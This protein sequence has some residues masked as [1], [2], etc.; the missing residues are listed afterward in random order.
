MQYYFYK[1][2]DNLEIVYVPVHLNVIFNEP[3]AI[4]GS[5]FL[6]DEI[7]SEMVKGIT[8]ETNKCYIIDFQNIKE[9]SS[10]ATKKFIDVLSPEKADLIF[11]NI[12]EAIKGQLFKE[13]SGYLNFTNFDTLKIAYSKNGWGYFNEFIGQGRDLNTAI[14]DIKEKIIA[15]HLKE[16][17]KEENNYLE[18]SNVYSKYYV[19]VKTVF[20]TS[21]VFYLV[22][23]EMCKNIVNN[24]IISNEKNKFTSTLDLVCVSNNGA[25]LSKIIGQVLNLNVLYLMNLGPHYCV[26][27]DDMLYKIKS[28]RNYLFV[29]DFI[30]LGT[31][32][33]ISKAILNVAN[34]EI[35]GAV[36][37][38][39]YVDLYRGKKLIPNKNGNIKYLI[40]VNQHGFNYEISSH[41][42]TIGG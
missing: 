41:E 28:G 33:K 10:R 31:E 24:F 17:M 13:C 35:I 30:C 14:K 29:C 39:K 22:I 1:Y 3:S 19:N 27:Q 8:N 23:Y 7:V 20:R 15:S 34:A 16:S 2:I 42:Y 25:V 26:K 21:N 18:S 36:S 37:V 5:D 6:S 38:A 40:D 12:N 9:V 4:W 11:C 32:Y